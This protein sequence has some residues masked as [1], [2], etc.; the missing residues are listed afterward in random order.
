MAVV[1]KSSMRLKDQFARL[2]KAV[3]L[4]SGHVR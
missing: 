4:A 1:G 3:R 2:Y